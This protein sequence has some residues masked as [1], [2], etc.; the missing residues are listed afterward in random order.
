MFR[1][2]KNSR[3]HPWAPAKGVGVVRAGQFAFVVAIFYAL[4]DT[5]YYHYFAVESHF[6]NI[7]FLTYFYRSFVLY[8][9]LAVVAAAA[10]AG[11]RAA[12]GKVLPRYVVVA[13]HATKVVDGHPDSRM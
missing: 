8:A 5:A 9:V 4:A 2:K 11:M 3:E 6:G 1:R 10:A 12:G 7:P 13:G